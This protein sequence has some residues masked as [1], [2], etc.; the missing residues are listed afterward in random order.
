MV[1]P[2]PRATSVKLTVGLIVAL[3]AA[4]PLR[5]LSPGPASAALIAAGLVAVV[6]GI[7]ICTAVAL[8]RR[9]AAFIY[10]VLFVGFLSQLAL[11]ASM[12]HNNLAGY[13]WNACLRAT[14]AAALLLLLS[15]LAR[16]W[17]AAADRRP[18]VFDRNAGPQLWR[19]TP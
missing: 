14:A 9:R 8:G 19:E 15:Q 6:V 13:V 1:T 2:P 3:F 5:D 11:S 4:G 17:L 16:I 12:L 18:V 7:A 10:L